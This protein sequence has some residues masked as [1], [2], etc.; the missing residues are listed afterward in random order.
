M[1]KPITIKTTFIQM[2][3][4]MVVVVT[5]IT[6]CNLFDTILITGSNINNSIILA[7]SNNATIFKTSKKKTVNIYHRHRVPIVNMETSMVI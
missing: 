7:G 2:M 3:E 4:V 6:E 5:F 1:E